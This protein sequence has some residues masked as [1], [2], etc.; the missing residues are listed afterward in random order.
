MSSIRSSGWA[1]PYSALFVLINPP[2]RETTPASWLGS[3]LGSSSPRT[4]VSAW[5]LPATGAVLDLREGGVQLAK[6]SV[7]QTPGKWDGVSVCAMISNIQSRW[8]LLFK[9]VQ[10][11]LL[12]R[13]Q[14]E[15]S[16]AHQ[17]PRS[18]HPPQ[19]CQLLHAHVAF[20]SLC[21][22]GTSQS[23]SA[24]GAFHSL[25]DVEGFFPSCSAH[26]AFHSLC[27]VEG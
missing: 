23:F 11:I 14:I 27:D 22:E 8:L 24:H 5:R 21:D 12:F 17:P 18:Y 13:L 1:L 7:K 26:E 3:A 15:C 4:V 6:R 25:C 20:Q 19:R 9:S 2:K 10:I 16:S